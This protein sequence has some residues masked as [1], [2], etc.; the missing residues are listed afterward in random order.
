MMPPNELTA[1]PKKSLPTLWNVPDP[2]WEL[3]D[4]VLTVYDPPAKTGRKRSDPRQAFDGII[5]RMRTGCQWN[6]LP[7][8]F[9][10]DS[11][12][13]RAFSRWEKKAIFD[14][15]WA[16]LLTKCDDLQG[17]DWHWQAADGCLGKAR[18]VPESGVGKRGR[19]TRV[20]VPAPV[21]ALSLASSGTIRKACWLKAMAGP[22]RLASAEPHARHLLAEGHAGRRG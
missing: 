14:I 5:Y 17:V 10:D 22:L 13:Y 11:S 16:I 18:G 4:K 12:V 8:E 21:T 15:L 7:Q 2:L 20:S 9:G 1:E 19:K 6:H 3:I